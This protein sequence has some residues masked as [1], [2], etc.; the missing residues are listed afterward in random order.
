[1]TRSTTSFDSGDVILVRF[2][3]TDLSGAKQ[4]PAVVLSTAAYS[5][6][7]GDLIFIP[8]T[9]QP[10]PDP[11]LALTDWSSAGLLRPTWVK[12]LIASVTQRA[13]A[14]AVGRVAATDVQAVQH[15]VRVM[16]D[17]QWLS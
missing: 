13:V 4:R 16:I 9:S 5:A 7:Y 10:Q 14:R 11:A 8:L 2:P 12:P 15:A 17:R 6:R 1:M 3:F